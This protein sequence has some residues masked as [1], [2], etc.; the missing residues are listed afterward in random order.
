MI[1]RLNMEQIWI[2]LKKLIYIKAQFIHI[3]TGKS[4]NFNVFMSIIKHLSLDSKKVC[5]STKLNDWTVIWSFF[6]YVFFV[7]PVISSC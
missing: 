5:I 7:Y 4:K 3:K 1:K 2:T 6:V